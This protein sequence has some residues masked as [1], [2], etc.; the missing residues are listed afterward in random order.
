MQRKLL[1]MG[2]V[3]VLVAG[4]IGLGVYYFFN[5]GF[6]AVI[7]VESGQGAVDPKNATYIID[8]QAVALRDGVSEVEAAP[9][10]ASKIVTKYF[11]NEVQI[12]LNGDGRLDTAFILTQT[13]GGSGTFYYAV[14]ALNT[15]VGYVGSDGYLLGDRIAPQATTKSQNPSQPEVVVFNYADRASGEPMTVRPSVGKSVY[16]KLN[17]DSMQWGIVQPNFEGEST[18]SSGQHPPAVVHPK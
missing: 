8:G 11:G 6:D 16:L 7:Q 15:P 18:S 2:G 17:T 9:G 5:P 4:A 13:G 3:G 1:V 14:A 12:D 10:S